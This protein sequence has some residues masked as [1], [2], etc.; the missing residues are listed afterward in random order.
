VVF[1]HAFESAVG[2]HQALHCAAA[3]GDALAV[4]GL[5]T[6]GVFVDDIA[7]PVACRQGVATV[8]DRPGLGIS[9]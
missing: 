3:W 5:C 6:A 9:P 7:E 1:S 4:H 8:S 2:A